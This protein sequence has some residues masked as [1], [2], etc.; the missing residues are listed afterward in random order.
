MPSLRLIEDI[1]VDINALKTFLEVAKTN[2]FGHAAET[3]HISRSTVSTRI[4][5][6][7]EVLGVELF[8]RERGNIHLSPSGEALITHAKSMM[9]LWTRAKQ[10]LAAPQ[11]ISQALAIGG[12]SGLWDITLQSWL[13]GVSQSH[14]DVALSADIFS[15]EALVAGVINGTIDMAFLYDAPQGINI[16]SYPLQTIK[17]RL[18]STQQYACLPDDWAAH[19]IQ[20]DW[21]MNFAVQ[22][23][24]HFPQISR[25]RLVTGLGRIAFEHLKQGDGFAYLAEPMVQSS[26]DN[27]ELF[28]VANTPIFE[29]KAYAIY[30]QENDKAGLIQ[31]LLKKL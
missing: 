27:G 29:R 1:S 4:H 9:T 23:A 15:A 13:Y 20:V 24:A 21:G 16:A 31:Q 2:H 8:I 14:P 5:T 6:L 19:F 7:E 3:L 18:V 17:L 25:S 11:G 30:H 12:L 10:E 22:F 26:I 28:Y